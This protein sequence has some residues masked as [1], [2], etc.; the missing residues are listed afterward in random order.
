MTTMNNDD[1]NDDDDDDDDRFNFDTD[2]P[3]LDYFSC[4]QSKK[5]MMFST[6]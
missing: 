1:D 3:S 5:Q 6:G 4:S 2:Q